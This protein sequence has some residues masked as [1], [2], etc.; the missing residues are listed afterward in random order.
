MICMM[1]IAIGLEGI[2]PLRAQ[3]CR[4]CAVARRGRVRGRPRA[5]M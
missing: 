4:G 1:V 3:A 2:S 5:A